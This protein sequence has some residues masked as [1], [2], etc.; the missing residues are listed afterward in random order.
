MLS[1]PEGVRSAVHNNEDVRIA[2]TVYDSTAL[3]PVRNTSQNLS[4]DDTVVGS[5]I[6]SG[7]VSEISGILLNPPVTYSL[8][9]INY[10]LLP[11]EYV[12]SRRCVFWD[13]NAASKM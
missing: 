7:L 3:F 11:N 2:F 9:L 13:F 4:A 12:T 8:R 6:V 5:Q 10:N 1:I